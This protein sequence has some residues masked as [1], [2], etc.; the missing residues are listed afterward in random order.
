MFIKDKSPFV[1]DLQLFNEGDEPPVVIP[2]YNSVEDDVRGLLGE[3]PPEGEPVAPAAE[4]PV[5]DPAAP[6]VVDPVVEPGAPVPPVEPEQP[7]VN[8]PTFNPVVQELIK[9]N[10]MLQQSMQQQSDM[11]QKL[12]QNTMT[13]NAPQPSPEVI[14]TP[15]EVEVEK[16]ALMERFYANPMEVLNEFA[17]KATEPLQKKLSAYEEK[18]AWNESIGTIARDTANFP[19]F[20]NVRARMSEILFKE[21][22]EL[23]NGVEKTDALAKAYRLALSEK[24]PVQQQPIAPAQAAPADMMK[25]P[26]FI[27]QLIG[28]PE[29]MKMIEMEKAKAIQANSQQV[30]PMSP[31]S[32]VANVAPYIKNAPSNY[33]EVEGDIKNSLHQGTL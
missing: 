28:N 5:V 7:P 4:P 13:N 30:P 10:Q 24:A 2:G 1:L 22:P 19:E 14:K 25:D 8:D 27:K 9:Q 31:S 11:M 12:I 18:E 16:E 26:E 20:E 23:L 32:G 33:D 17:T 6:P 3:Q 21:M 29:V 15:E